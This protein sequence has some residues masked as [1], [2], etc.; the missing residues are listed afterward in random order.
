MAVLSVAD[1]RRRVQDRINTVLSPQGWRPSR[2][3]PDLFG[4]DTDQIAPR[5]FSVGVGPSHPIGD[6]Q[7]IPVGTVVQ[8]ML[9]V[10][11]V[12]RIRGDA[13]LDD[14]DMALDAEEDLLAAVIGTSLVDL[15]IRLDSIPTRT[16]F[17]DGNWFLG[18]L[19]FRT[20]H[21]LPL[22]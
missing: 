16:V 7:R 21:R 5:V 4:Q 1:V 9:N 2:F 13:Q 12:W 11:F 6:R 8:T 18:E 20:E 15:H 3:V 14:Y 19:V 17:A 22:T 10:R